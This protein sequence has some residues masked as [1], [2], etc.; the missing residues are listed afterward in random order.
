MSKQDMM[1][2]CMTMQI[3]LRVITAHVQYRILCHVALSQ[4]LVVFLS[5]QRPAVN[6]TLVEHALGNK[7]NGTNG[8]VSCVLE[9]TLVALVKLACL[10]VP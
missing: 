3:W 6:V 2:I 9:V 5:K 8:Y 7:C 4:Q 1:Y 10:H